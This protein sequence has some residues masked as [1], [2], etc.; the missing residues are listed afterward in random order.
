MPIL[1]SKNVKI[2][3]LNGNITIEAPLKTGM[4]KIGFGDVAIFDK[5]TSRSI[6]QINGNLIFRGEASIGHGSKIS[7]GE[8]GNLVI[9]NNFRITAESEI[10]CYKRIEIGNDCLFSWKILLMDTDFHKIFNLD[11]TM[12]LNIAKEIYIG[13]KNWVGCRTVILKGVHTPANTVIAANSTVTKTFTK[14]NTIIGGNPA[15]I[16]KENVTWEK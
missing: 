5:R 15:R 1:V 7:V 4:I 14:E 9:G 10:I 8:S 16:L 6:L 2:R 3:S 11:K 13:D 12:V